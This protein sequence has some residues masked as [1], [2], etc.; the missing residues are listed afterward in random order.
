MKR[1]CKL[2]GKE[3]EP[4][5]NSQKI[6]T[7]AHT[8]PCPVCGKLIEWKGYNRC[9][10]VKCSN[11]LRVKTNLERY[12]VSNVSQRNMRMDP[13]FGPPKGEGIYKSLKVHAEH[14][15]E[16]SPIIFK[17]ILDALD[18][19]YETDFQLQDDTTYT[20]QFKVGNTLVCIDDTLSANK[21]ARPTIRYHQTFTTVGRDRGYRVIHLFDWDNVILI[22]MTL[23]PK[24]RIHARNCKVEKIDAYTCDAFL[25]MNHL[26]GTV[27][28]QKIRYGLYHNN[29]LVQVMTFGRSR[30]TNKYQYE[31]LR[32]CSALGVQ[33][34]GGASKLFQHF[35]KEYDPDSVLSYC[36]FSK[37][38]GDVYIKM[39]MQHLRTT[40]P[41]LI[42]SR[43]ADKMYDRVLHTAG[44]DNLF[45]ASFG[46]AHNN[47]QLMQDSGWL[48]V[49]DCGQAV[50]S[51]IKE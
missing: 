4:T 22:A 24:T 45:G 20:Y 14:I 37:F 2:C 15:Q 25:K 8:K 46:K 35:I 1:I 16:F 27:V 41:G 5:N 32:M 33:V 44:Y 36:D 18:I 13:P 48:P 28:N 51:Y 10:S 21:Y 3:F 43:G 47:A 31:M 40:S 12:G 30:Y 49:Y 6:C 34:V 17:S 26:Q 9:C 29:D 11:K 23:Q 39:G 42:W 38:T 50:Y 7:R 19:S